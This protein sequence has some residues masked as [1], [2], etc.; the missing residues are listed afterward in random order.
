V[1]GWIRIHVNYWWTC[2]NGNLNNGSADNDPEFSNDA[3]EVNMSLD[4]VCAMST[5]TGAE[6]ADVTVTAIDPAGHSTQTDTTVA[7]SPD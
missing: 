2:E 6:P 3:L 1:A 4:M 7:L 5:F